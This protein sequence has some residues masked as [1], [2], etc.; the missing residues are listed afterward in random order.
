M[1]DEAATPHWSDALRNILHLDQT[2]EQVA[3]YSVTGYARR[4]VLDLPYLTDEA[5]LA[6]Q[7]DNTAEILALL[8]QGVYPGVPVSSQ[9]GPADVVR[10]PE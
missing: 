3:D 8:E 4:I 10:M 2:L 1:P 6:R 5:E 9:V 7:F